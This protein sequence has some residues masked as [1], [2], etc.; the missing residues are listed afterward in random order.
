MLDQIF[1]GYIERTKGPFG[2]PFPDPPS[3]PFELF[4]QHVLLRPSGG[5][6]G[7]IGPFCIHSCIPFKSRIMNQE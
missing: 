2:F 3:R 7:P 5:A 6:K 1:N 4:I